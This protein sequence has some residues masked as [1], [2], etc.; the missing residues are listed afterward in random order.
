MRIDP[1]KC[2]ACGNCLAVCPMGAI[3]I[4]PALNRARVN[5]DECVECFACYR[6]MSRE[7]LNPRFV[8]AIRKAAHLLRF[9]F[10]PEPDICPTDAFA[11]DDLQWPRL[12]RRAFSDPQ[13]PHEST[14]IHGRGTAEVKTNDVTRRVGEGEAGFVIEFGRPGVGARFRD[15]ERVTRA[16]AE[17]GIEFEPDN[18]VTSLM[19][20]RKRGLLDPEILDEKVLSAIVEIKTRLE[21]VPMVLRRIRR[22]SPEVNTVISIGVSTRCGAG[23]EE[24]LRE[25]LEREGYPTYRGKTNLGL[26]RAA[27]VHD[28]G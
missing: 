27:A 19:S 24:P 6:G 8:R 4:D 11:P 12:V 15:I 22:I 14:G 1:E 3:Y 5:A 13:V 10:D 20:D 2:V 28:A 23:G 21:E 9:R 16:L 17:L 7:H 18:P 26:G 25:M